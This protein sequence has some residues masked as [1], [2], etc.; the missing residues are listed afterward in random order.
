MIICKEFPDKQF[1]SKDEM[2][3][4][5]VSHADKIISL[6]KANIFN[7]AEK[8]QFGTFDY[9]AL[10]ESKAEF[11]K[12]GYIYPVINTTKYFDSHGDVHF[13]GIWNKS[14]KEQKGNLFYVENH[15]LKTGSVIAWPEN[16]NAFV[17]S[18]PWSFVGKNYDG[19]TEAL[20]FEIKES[21]IENQ[22]AKDIISKRRPVQNS[23]RMQY[24]KIR[25]AIN[26]NNKDY[27]ENKTYWDNRINDI[28]NKEAVEEQGYFWGIEEAKIVKEGSMVLF[29]S[30]DATPIQ[31]TEAA[32][33]TSAK[34]E[35]SDNDTQEQKKNRITFI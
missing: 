19:E 35:P 4:H 15:E 30:N 14:V 10:N 25:L 18:V 16:V 12:D 17:K 23:V 8:G 20:I 1:A 24:V 33:S 6:K 13:D 29:G 26:D 27:A 5:L 32:E 3:K 34:T 7:S 2:F 28:A 22:N 31:Y 11:M 9:K 21:D